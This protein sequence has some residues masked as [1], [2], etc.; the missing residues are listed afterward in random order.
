MGELQEWYRYKAD[1]FATLLAREG[2]KED[3]CDEQRK[4]CGRDEEVPRITGELE[5]Q[6]R[7]V[8]RGRRDE[9]KILHGSQ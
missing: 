5:C 9:D 4:G 3:G 7:E 1:T 2:R 6:G 8:L